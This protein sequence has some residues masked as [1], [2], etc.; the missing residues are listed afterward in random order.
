MVEFQIQSCPLPFFPTFEKINLMNRFFIVFCFLLTLQTAQ[1]Q[2]S[3]LSGIVK[4]SLSKT[5]IAYASIGLMDANDKIVD[6]M[7]TDTAGSFCFSN[8]KNG[9]YSLTIKFIGYD[10]K[11]ARVE[12]KGQKTVDLGA[13]LISC[14]D[15]SLEQITVTANGPEQ[16]HSSDRQIY[17]T[18]QYKNAVGGTALDIV[19]NLPSASIDANGNISMRGNIGIIVLVN[20]KPSF[21]DPA[22]I[23]N[24]IAANDV[25]AVEYITSPTAQFD[26]D[27]KGGIINLKT[28]KS[29]INGFAWR[30]NLQG[31]LPS[32]DDY[33][34]RESQQ[35]FG[36]D[37]AFQYSQGKLELNGSANY[38]RNDNAGFRDGDVNTIIGN[39]QTFFPSKGERSFDKYNFGIRL[40]SAYEISDKHSVNLGVLASRRFQDRVA[41]IHY[42]NRTIEPSTG[43]EISRTYYFNPNL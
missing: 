3:K 31:G 30:L 43:Q 13:I 7:M 42:D 6:G 37:I 36:G 1:A 41:D 27:G 5:A 29:A 23:L 24:Q 12:I 34:N 20:G 25:A 35:R 40:N 32:L 8:L 18:S 33:N 16:K 4:D 26:P 11:E 21:L 14:A 2:N 17:Q 9:K 19:K 22:T 38:L 39:R 15:N 28:K 10:Q